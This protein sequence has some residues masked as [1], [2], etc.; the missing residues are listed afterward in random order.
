MVFEFAGQMSDPPYTSR[1]Y[2]PSH[3]FSKRCSPSFSQIYF[4][5]N[6]AVLPLF[7]IGSLGISAFAQT[8]KSE[9]EPLAD[10]VVVLRNG[11]GQKIWSIDP[12]FIED[13]RRSG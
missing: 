10:A 9:L 6:V 12:R 8:S 4:R 5:H 7:T 11:N 2:N 3:S 13:A 1:S